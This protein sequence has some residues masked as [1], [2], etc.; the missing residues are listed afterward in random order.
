ME[1]LTYSVIQ[2]FHNV[3]AIGVVAAPTVIYLLLGNSDAIVKTNYIA[4]ALASWLIQVLSG[5]GFGV[6]SF[7]FYG[8]IPD[9]DGV[10]LVALVVKVICAMLSMGLYLYLLLPKSQ[11]LRAHKSV[12]RILVVASVLPLVSA[13]FLRWY[14]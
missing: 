13:A 12:W 4:I 1:N 8:Q 9:I 6:T 5:I 11:G 2:A 14:G 7:S 3:G 10:A